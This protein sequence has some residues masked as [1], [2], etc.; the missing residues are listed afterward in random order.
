MR[1]DYVSPDVRREQGEVR[2]AYTV[3]EVA[4]MLGMPTSTVYT[5]VRR[6]VIPSRKIGRWVRIPADWLERFI[7]GE[8]EEE[9]AG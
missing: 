7:A 1:T 9:G 2:L 5:N 8:E 3:P 6:G 4:R